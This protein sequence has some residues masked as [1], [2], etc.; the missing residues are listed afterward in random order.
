LT[1]IG[2]LATFRTLVSYQERFAGNDCMKAEFRRVPALDKCFTILDFFVK[3]KRPLGISEIS[4]KLKINKSTVFNIVHTLSDLQVLEGGPDGKFRFGT[5]LYTLGRAAGDGADLIRTVHPYLEEIG[6]QTHL[7][8]LFGIRSALKTVILDK[9]DTDYDLKIS[10]EIGQV[11]PLLAGAAGMALLSQLPDSEI[12]AILRKDPFKKFTA[13]T[14]VDPKAYKE[15]VQKVR[16][17]RIALDREEYLEGIIALAVPIKT[18][19]RNIEAAIWAVGLK[20]QI[21]DLMIAE[22]SE[23]LKNAARDIEVRFS[24]V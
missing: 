12:D 6:K 11:I 18:Y 20:W 14:C 1:F 23:L 3:S 24:P 13:K 15:A 7:S 10:S 21:P 19:R 4:K 16:V 9:V 5:R 22:I 8:V 17:E 2:A